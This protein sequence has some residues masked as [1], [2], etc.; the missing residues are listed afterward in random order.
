MLARV[1]DQREPWDLAVVG[2]G[3]TGAGI[4]VDAATRGYAVLLLEQSDFGKG[5]SSRSTKLV[6][7]G[8]R[9]LRQGNL[10]L[11]REGLR[12]RW[13]LRQNAPHLVQ[14]RAF[15]VPNYRWWDAPFYGLGL[16]GY[17]L[18]AGRYGFGPTT[19][20]SR[21]EALTRIP[22]LQ[23]RD[24]RGGV[25]YYDGQFDD[26]RLL[27]NLVQTAADHGGCAANYAR[28]V[29]L[30]KDAE[31]LI[32]GLTFEDAESQEVHTIKAR[33]V[34]NATGVFCDELRRQDDPSDRPLVTPSQ[35]THLV[36]DRSFLPGD[37]AL[38]APRTKDGRIMFAIPWQSQ[39]LIGTTDTAIDQI[40]LE[41]RPLNQEVEFL[42]RTAADYLSNPPSR[43]DVLS[44]FAGIRPL[45]RSDTAATTAQLQR[46]H[47]ILVSRSGLI[48]IT[49]G[50]WTT[51]RKMAEDAVDQAIVTARLPRRGCHTRDL[52]IHGYHRE[53]GQFGPLA[54]YGADAPGLGQL[55]ASQPHLAKRLHPD[56]L[57]QAAQV[58]WAVRHEMARTVEDVLARRTRALF[59]RSR[60]AAAAA[61][62]VAELMAQELSRPPEWRKAQ[63]IEFQSLA[64][65]YVG[66][67]LDATTSS[68]PL[69]PPPPAEG[70]D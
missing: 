9:Y 35:G 40:S 11:V 36:L 66:C 57:I 19:L 15:L 4:A 65:G 46:D 68:G 13:L 26:S 63:V 3:A 16:K 43:A 51:Y 18:L 24:L 27:I 53:P 39:V 21:A 22:T 56:L 48:T 41:P 45:V 20:L 14:S 25:V 8:V 23:E 61:P 5:T 33:G 69:I 30:T 64:K 70:I 49:G 29:G 10:A 44:V 17:D 38:M 2:G 42:L 58:V 12:E 31:G 62:A 1:R 28:V 50:K 34:I 59:L 47:K 37:T 7:G 60:A 55:L 67:S 54:P 6:H 52:R 32:N